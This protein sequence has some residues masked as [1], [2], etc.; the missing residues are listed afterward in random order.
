M[1]EIILVNQ[2]I[3]NYVLC[4]DF[5]LPARRTQYFLT[6]F[7]NEKPQTKEHKHTYPYAKAV[8]IITLELFAIL[9]FIWYFIT[10]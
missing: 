3:S 8:I 7:T 9:P 10:R 5:H 1:T 4:E 6:L 2:L